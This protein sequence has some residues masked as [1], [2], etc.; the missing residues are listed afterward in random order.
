M[1]STRL[2]RKPINYKPEHPAFVIEFGRQKHT[3]PCETPLKHG[4]E[5]FPLISCINIA[6]CCIVYPTAQDYFAQFWPQD[7]QNWHILQSHFLW[8]KLI[9]ASFA[10]VSKGITIAVYPELHRKVHASFDA[11]CNNIGCATNLWV[12]FKHKPDISRSLPS[13][14]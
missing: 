14:Y 5:Y 7:V 6:R 4:N 10:S 2:S 12:E 3:F 8:L 13:D 11:F 9:Y 1:I